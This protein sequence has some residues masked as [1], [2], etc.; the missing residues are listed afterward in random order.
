M[1]VA[2]AFAAPAEQAAI[3]QAHRDAAHEAMTY[4]E[5]IIGRARIGDGGREGFEPGHV[6]WFA[7]D[8]YTARPTLTMAVQK[9]GQTGHRDG[10]GAGAG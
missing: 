8:H 5:T 9:D 6:G 3:W 10:S 7:F 4:L 2:W 1:S